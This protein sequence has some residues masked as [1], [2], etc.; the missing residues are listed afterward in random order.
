M[1]HVVIFNMVGNAEKQNAEQDEEN[2]AEQ[3]AKENPDAAAIA[4]PE[5]A[6]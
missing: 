1:E 6:S 5:N 3:D 2:D 4:A